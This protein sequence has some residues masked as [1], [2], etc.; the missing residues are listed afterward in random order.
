MPLQLPVCRKI[1]AMSLAVLFICVPAFP[2]AQVGD[3]LIMDGKQ[4]E[5]Q[6]NPLST[7]LEQNPGRMPKSNVIST[8][9]WRGYIATWELKD[10]QLLLQ[11]VTISVGGS[12]LETEQRSV[13]A[14]VF[15]Q[16]PP[17]VAEWFTGNLIIPS[18]RLK[19][20]V[21]MGYASTYD[22]YII[23]TI[24]EGIML[25][26]WK[27]NR[28]TFAKFRSSQ[29]AEFQ[30]TSEYQAAMKETTSGKDPMNAAD[31]NE[32]IRQYYSEQY[33]SRVF[34]PV[35]GKSKAQK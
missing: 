21:H 35:S 11:D 18:G 7:F 3:I 24:Q 27:A 16:K 30:K 20:Y 9:N 17:V 26:R 25:R 29:F 33:M 15:P 8:S 1:L 32:F 6:T 13:I 12:G 23:V 22:N 19:S 10:G 14:Q 28:S 2:T 5:I 31:A 4:Y 34:K